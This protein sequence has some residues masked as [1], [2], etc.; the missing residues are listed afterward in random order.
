MLH[1]NEEI[2]SQLRKQSSGGAI[3]N[4]LTVAFATMWMLY[5]TRTFLNEVEFVTEKLLD[6]ALF[7]MKV[8][9]DGKSCFWDTSSW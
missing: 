8:Y 6:F 1:L 2:N 4:V 5:W 3:G 9:V 7:L